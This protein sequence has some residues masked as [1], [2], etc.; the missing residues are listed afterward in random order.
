MEV[1][2]CFSE[3]VVVDSTFFVMTL[4]P[5]YRFVSSCFPFVLF[6]HRI[7]IHTGVSR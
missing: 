5:V 6:M 7:D 1:K 4:N 3:K 2:R